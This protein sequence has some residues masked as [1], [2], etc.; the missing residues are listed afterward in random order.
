MNTEF[1]GQFCAYKGEDT[2]CE[3]TNVLLEVTEVQG[4][5]VE[6]STTTPLPGKPRIYIKF[7]LPELVAHC[8]PEEK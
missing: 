6:I 8:L 1:V 7:N 4:Q 2:A 5:T 3:E